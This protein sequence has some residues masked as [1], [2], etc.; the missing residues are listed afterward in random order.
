MISKILTYY[1]IY[2]Y[3]IY[4]QQFTSKNNMSRILKSNTD[5]Y[6]LGDYG[7]IQ[8]ITNRNYSLY[9]TLKG[10]EWISTSFSDYILQRCIPTN[11]FLI[12]PTSQMEKIIDT[13]LKKLTDKSEFICKEQIK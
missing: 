7:K 11:N 13:N 4:K 5:S 8:P 1:I 6:F 10:P 3:L 2:Y 9:R 12:F